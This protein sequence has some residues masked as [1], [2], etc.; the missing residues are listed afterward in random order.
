MALDWMKASSQRPLSSES[1]RVRQLLKIKTPILKTQYIP[2]SFYVVIRFSF[3]AVILSVKA[4][5]VS[6]GND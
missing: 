4:Y 6:A 5:V 3:F 2:F 1:F